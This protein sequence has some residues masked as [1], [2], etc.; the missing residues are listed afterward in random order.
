MTEFERLEQ[1]KTEIAARL[2]ELRPELQKA[3][4]LDDEL[5]QKA[6]RAEVGKLWVESQGWRDAR[7]E[8][9]PKIADLEN[10][11]NSLIDERDA[12]T[13]RSHDL[14]GERRRL[15]AEMGE[16]LLPVL[17]LC[18]V[19]PADVESQIAY[20]RERYAAI[21]EPATTT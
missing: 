18:L 2:A 20:K 21:G 3:R 13:K 9:R 16:A 19:G 4:Q 1:R 11:M 6:G 12:L 14:L 5:R 8:L 10:D 17:A 7:A 15:L